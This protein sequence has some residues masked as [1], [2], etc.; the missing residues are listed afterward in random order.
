[1]QDAVTLLNHLLQAGA[2]VFAVGIT[3]A[4]LR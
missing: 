1:V 2:A 4:L 3:L